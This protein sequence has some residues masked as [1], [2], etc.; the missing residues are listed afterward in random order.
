MIISPSLIPELDDL[1]NQL[2]DVAG[3]AYKSLSG[4][5]SDLAPYDLSDRGRGTDSMLSSQ[6]FLFNRNLDTRYGSNHIDSGTGRKL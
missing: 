2:V 6:T 1:P 3:H 5:L 4:G